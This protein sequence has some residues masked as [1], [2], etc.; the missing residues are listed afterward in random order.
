MSQPR[1]RFFLLAFQSMLSERGEHRQR[2][3]DLA[4][5]TNQP[6]PRV[7]HFFFWRKKRMR[8]AAWIVIKRCGSGCASFF[9]WLDKGRDSGPQAGVEAR[10]SGPEGTPASITFGPT[11]R[12]LSSV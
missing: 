2:A 7:A 8:R 9:L 11:G 12:T 1:S 5:S 10:V 3:A 4:A 6:L